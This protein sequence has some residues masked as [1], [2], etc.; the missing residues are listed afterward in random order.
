[1]VSE[2]AFSLLVCTGIER[3]AVFHLERAH[4]ESR[5]CRVEVKML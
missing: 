3:S 1:M 5:L 4:F 2:T